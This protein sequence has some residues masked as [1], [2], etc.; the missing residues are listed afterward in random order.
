[1]IVFKGGNEVARQA[2]AMDVTR[3]MQWL[4]PALG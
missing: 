1:L 4:N 2:G 3:L